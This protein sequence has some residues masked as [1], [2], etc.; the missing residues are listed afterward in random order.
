VTFEQ[1]FSGRM[2][3][4]QAQKHIAQSSIHYRSEG[5]DWF[6]V[7]PMFATKAAEE[8]YFIVEHALCELEREFEAKRSRRKRSAAKAA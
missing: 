1:I 7:L 2:V 8:A 3:L 4:I 5:T 6:P